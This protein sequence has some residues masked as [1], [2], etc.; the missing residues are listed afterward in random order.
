MAVDQTTIVITTHYIEEAR[1]AHL[2]CIYFVCTHQFHNHCLI[3][4]FQVGLMRDGI[5]LAEDPPTSL[6]QTH[7]LLV[8]A[9]F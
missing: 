8:S 2:V 1:Q 6:I 7:C 4:L 3:T 5:L 9:I